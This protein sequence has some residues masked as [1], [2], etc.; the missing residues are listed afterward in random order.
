MKL[1]ELINAGA[2]FIRPKVGVPIKNNWKHGKRMM[3][4]KISRQNQTIQA[5]Q[6][7]LK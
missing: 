4:T 2:K 1:N 7:L 6:N 5:K 3:T